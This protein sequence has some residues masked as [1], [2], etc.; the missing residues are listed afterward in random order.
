MSDLYYAYSDYL[1]KKYH[2]KVYKLPISLPVTCPN[3]K[4]GGRGCAFCAGQGTGFEAANIG[5]SVTEQLKAARKQIEAKYHAHKFIAYF[6]NYTNTY[7]PPADFKAYI[8]E[9]AG[10]EDIVEI[11]VSTRPDCIRDDYLE[12]LKDVSEGFSVRITVEL[13]LQT[14]NY[15]TLARMGRGHGLAEFID[16]IMRIQ[17]FGFEI[18][19]HV[20]LN[21]P[22]DTLTDSIETAK[23]LSALN[24]PV[25]K[26]HSLYIPKN[27]LLCDWY[28]DGKIAVCSKEE[29]LDRLVHFIEY[30]SPDT[31]IERL[32]SR[33]PEKDSAF[34][35]WGV[36][37]WRLRDEF[38]RKM[39][40]RESFQGKQFHYLNGSA[41]KGL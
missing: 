19:V 14:A 28:K 26:I 20:I 12:I 36:S 9:A 25:V 38:E 16:A 11:A 32:F 31:A 21:L 35:N 40:E 13:G 23:L 33:I 39:T 37:W 17:R 10:E 24:I 2:E 22:G 4:D 3:R 27:S 15:H 34:S 8:S 29:Y 41:L 5:A 1:K 30:L 6:Q 18:C 7:L